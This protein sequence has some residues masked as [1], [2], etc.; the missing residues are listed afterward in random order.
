MAGNAPSQR[1]RAT[2]SSDKKALQELFLK[3]LAEGMTVNAAIESVGRVRKTYEQWR[4]SDPNF[5][6]RADQARQLRQNDNFV[7]GEQ[8]GFAEFRLKYLHA[9]TYRHQMQ[10]V[11]IIEG[12]EPRD[13]H[14]AQTYVKGKRNRILILTPPFHAKSI[15]LTVD[16][17][18]YRLCMDPS[19][20]IL[21]VSAGAQLA[22]DFLFGV[23]QRL[24][25][26]DYIELQK[27]YAPTGGWEATAEQWTNDRIVFATD[28]RASGSHG[29]SEKDPN[30]Q[31]I[32]MRG[33]IYGKR[34]DLVI[35]DDSVDGTN[36][37]DYQK[38]FKW[39][40]R[41]VASR[42]EA[43][44]KLVMVGTRIA[45]M[46][47]YSYL[48]DAETYGGRTPPWTHL[49][50]PAI[51]EEGPTPAECVTLWPYAEQPWGDPKNMDMDDC[52]C[53]DTENCWSNPIDVDGEMLYPRWD[54]THIDKG[55][56][57]DNSPQEFAL[58][59]QQ[60]S[61]GDN[62]T[63]PQHA[64][65]KCINS[66]RLPGLLHADQQGHPIGGMK[67]KY[68]LAGCDP[69]V[70]GFAA[71][72]ILAVDKET[73][74]RYLLAAINMKAPTPNELK[75][76][77]FRV[78]DLYGVNE[79]RIEKTGLLQFFTQDLQLRTYM[80]SR[81]VLL[82][83]HNTGKN[84]WDP[85]FGVASMQGLFGIWDRA[86]GPHGEPTSDWRE[87]SPPMIEL[88][89]IMSDGLKA[90]QHQL[91][92]WTPELD[93]NRVPCDL[94]MAL[95]FAEIG[96]RDITKRTVNKDNVIPI[97]AQK[98]VTQRSRQRAVSVSMADARMGS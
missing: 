92:I 6:I 11:D 44:G 86:T 90:L 65:A 79:W 93:P 19:Y 98:F 66:W 91:I 14:D 84:K 27:A 63:F 42:I 95:W 81:G 12:R 37:N 94:V 57:A 97:R 13:L 78:T 68:I 2:P 38:Q 50:S 82:R 96:A 76:E 56:R 54:G 48:M 58:V 28:V 9:R 51:L 75:Q 52:S 16:Y 73:H 80:T 10:W 17:S 39:L 87:V 29:T 36:V 34:A 8:I 83:E 21:C 33:K 74:K 62:S 43:G 20:R 25:G 24:T 69:S 72:I 88:P 70:K 26:P 7:R 61:V 85:V 71:L 77:M 40:M 55:P 15:T 45:S 18:V 46:D 64:V 60:Q 1:A 53:E 5:A 41:E 49:A 30:F 23:K 4:A 47:L 3:R 22:Q 67:N 89:K 35:V 32:G 31:A 59:Y